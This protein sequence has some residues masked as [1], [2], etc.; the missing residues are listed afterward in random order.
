MSAR[1]RAPAPI[2][3]TTAAPTT[4]T[5][6]RTAAPS[7]LQMAATATRDTSGPRSGGTTSGPRG[8]GGTFTG[9]T[10]DTSPTVSLPDHLMPF[11]PTTMFA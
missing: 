10:S 4:R 8:G 1:R 5:A 2:A 3:P 9:P 7:N 11:Q 6:P